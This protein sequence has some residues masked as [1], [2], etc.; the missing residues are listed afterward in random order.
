MK[1][2]EKIDL[3]ETIIILTADHG[4]RLPGTIESIQRNLL[5]FLPRILRIPEKQ[6]KIFWFLLFK[7]MNRHLPFLKR[8]QGH[9]FDLKESVIRVPLIF[10]GGEFPSNRIINEQVLS[11]IHI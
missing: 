4:E 1:F 5:T 2:L 3:D 11:L 10:S 9:G 8:K 6:E 7:K